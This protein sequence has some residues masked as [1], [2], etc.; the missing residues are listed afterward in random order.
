MEVL[1]ERKTEVLAG[2]S[3]DGVFSHTF[4]IPALGLK[5]SKEFRR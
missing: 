1:L 2:V 3:C 5:E 4:D